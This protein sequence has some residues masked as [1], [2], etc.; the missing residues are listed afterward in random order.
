LLRPGGLFFSYSPSKASDAFRNPA[1]SR[2][3]DSSTLDG[4]HRETSLFYGNSYPF[5]FIAREEYETALA[6][7]S[8]RAIYNETAGR[9]YNRGS[10]YFEFVVIAAER[11]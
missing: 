10:E 3:I 9:T 11:L 6:A 4:I 7:R 8:L 1:P 5:C 2:H